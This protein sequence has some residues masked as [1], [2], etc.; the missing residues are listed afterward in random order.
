M[1]ILHVIPFLWSGAGNVLTRLC[2]AQ[3]ANNDVGIITSGRSKGFTDWTEYRKRL[4]SA[5]VEHF[6]IDFFDRDPAVFWRSVEAFAKL[7][8]D[9]KPDVIHCHSGVPACAAALSGLRFIGQIHSWGMDRPHWMNAMDLIGF[10]SAHRML[11]GSIAYQK[12]LIDGGVD[13]ARICYLPWGLDLKEIQKKSGYTTASS[14]RFRIGFLGRV[15]PRKGQLELVR[16]FREFHQRH[17]QSQLEF[18][19]PTADKN[20]R[21]E[22]RGFLVKTGLSESVK[23]W[24]HLSNPYPKVKSWSLFTSLSGDEGQGIAILEAMSLGIPVLGR[25]VAGVEDYLHDGQTGLSVR[26]SCPEEVVDR[27]EWA[28]YHKKDLARIASRAKKMVEAEYNWDST[29][30]KMNGLYENATT[31]SGRTHSGLD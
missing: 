4:K 29:L 13:R 1:R 11:C 31:S 17:P 16:A 3:T 10:R 27:M 19:G 18:V 23:L 20:Y 2:A 30:E 12:I 8:R 5:G 24:G 6:E 15:E 22:I 7:T 25:R 14:S 28:L 26:S 21:E 9:W